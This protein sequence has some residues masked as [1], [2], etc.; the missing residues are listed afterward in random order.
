MELDPEESIEE[1]AMLCLLDYLYRRREMK[2][3]DHLLD[4]H[5]REIREKFYR[6]ILGEMIRDERKELSHILCPSVGFDALEFGIDRVD[7]TDLCDFGSE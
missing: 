1:E 3:M 5:E 6:E 4:S 7:A 2:C